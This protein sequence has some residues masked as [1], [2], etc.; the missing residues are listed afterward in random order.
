MDNDIRKLLPQ[1]KF[2]V[3]YAGNI[4]VMQNVEV[5][6]E[7]AR[8]SEDPDVLFHIFGDGAYKQKLIEKASDLNNVIFGRC[9]PLI[10]HLPCM[11]VRM[12]TSYHLRKIS[13]V[14]HCQ[15]RQQRVWLSMHH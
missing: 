13:I 11:P 6:I 10:K 5:V 3:V 15:V 9:N 8:K 12:L 4:G 2:N 14:Q 7:A 1:N